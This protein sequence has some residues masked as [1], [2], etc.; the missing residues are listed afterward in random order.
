MFGMFCACRSCVTRN[1]GERAAASP[2]L[3]AV[4]A[5]RAGARCII[6]T[7]A[8]GAVETYHSAVIERTIFMCRIAAVIFMTCVAADSV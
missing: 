8:V 5:N 3:V 6:K 7:A 1:T 4:T 2:D